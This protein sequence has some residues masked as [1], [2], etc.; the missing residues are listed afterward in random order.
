MTDGNPA[1]RRYET[2]GFRLTGTY[3][4]VIVPGAVPD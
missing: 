1:R 3:L 4:T 2:L